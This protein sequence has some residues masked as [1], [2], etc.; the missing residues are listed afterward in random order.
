MAFI[1]SFPP[2]PAGMYAGAMRGLA[3]LSIVLSVGVVTPLHAAP[4]APMAQEP[5]GEP[6]LGVQLRLSQPPVPPGTS[7]QTVE[8]PPLAVEIKNLSDRVISYNVMDLLSSSVEIDGVEYRTVI[9]GSCCG[10]SQA[11]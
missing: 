5:W 4:P 7:F 3:A 9:A 11:I 10:P 1:S 2:C 6:V 8:L